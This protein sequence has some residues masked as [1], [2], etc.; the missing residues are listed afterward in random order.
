MIAGNI[1]GYNGG[2]NIP[3]VSNLKGMLDKMALPQ[4][5]FLIQKVFLQE[6]F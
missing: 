4:Q 3:A 2:V 6:N 5:M 1:P